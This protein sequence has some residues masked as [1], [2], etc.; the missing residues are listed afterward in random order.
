MGLPPGA[1]RPA[2]S[3]DARCLDLQSPPK[4]PRDAGQTTRPPTTCLI[5]KTE[6][7]STPARGC[8]GTRLASSAWGHTPSRRWPHGCRPAPFSA[9]APKTARGARALPN[10]TSVFGLMGIRQAM[11]DDFARAAAFVSSWPEVSFGFAR[12]ASG[13]DFYLSLF[14][15]RS[16]AASGEDRASGALVRPRGRPPC[17]P[18]PFD[19]PCWILA[20]RAR[21]DGARYPALRVADAF[22]V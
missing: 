7:G 16:G 8:G 19:P 18:S 5:P 6:V 13:S 2:T 12:Q 22:P 21:E 4:R 15:A 1:G 17:V 11:S 20:S 9:R 10:S 14:R 3:R